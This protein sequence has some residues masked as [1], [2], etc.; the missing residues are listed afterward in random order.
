VRARKLAE[1]VELPM[2]AY[3]G[4]DADKLKIDARM[5]DILKYIG[6]GCP[7]IY[8]MDDWGVRILPEYRV[9]VAAQL[10][11]MVNALEMAGIQ[12]EIKVI[13]PEVAAKLHG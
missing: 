6:N 7:N 2:L 1:E 10:D 12:D 11:Q 4:I 5:I 8:Y 13:A 9:E 3:R